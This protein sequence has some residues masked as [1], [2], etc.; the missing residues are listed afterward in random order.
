[1]RR[2]ARPRATRVW[3]LVD[4]AA[5]LVAC[6]VLVSVAGLLLWSTAPL[7]VGWRS[8]AVVSG[9]MTPHLRIGDVVVTSPV[10]G[11]QVVP[12]QVV[13]FPDPSGVPRTLVHRIAS[14]DSEGRLITRGDANGSADSTPLPRSAVEGLGRL[15]VPFVGLP[16]VWWQTRDLPRLA[17]LTVLLLGSG[18]VLSLARGD[19]DD[20]EDRD[21]DRE[22]DGDGGRRPVPAPRG[23]GERWPHRNLAATAV[24]GAAAL[25]APLTGTPPA[26]ASFTSITSTS[27]TRSFTAGTVVLSSSPSTALFTVSNAGNMIPGDSATACL[28]ATYSGSLAASVRLRAAPGSS[29]SLAQYLKTTIEE[30]TAN[31]AADC[32]G[33][34]S[35]TTVFT[36]RLDTFL[37]QT[38]Y[39][40]GVGSWSPTGPGQVHSYRVTFQMWGP[41]TT[42][43]TKAAQNATSTFALAVEAQNT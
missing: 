41:G 4:A 6:T 7:A 26:E 14:V 22:V 16:R 38:T 36:G 19:E 9:S 1:M 3:S 43:G 29:G 10:D 37:A 31:A 24:V 21:R 11:A 20:D 27:S 42:T 30:S 13:L 39:A 40:T 34:T 33:F 8:S 2:P 25:L 12:G 28:T 35:P 23:P 5:Q 15:R 32:T 17:G 18:V